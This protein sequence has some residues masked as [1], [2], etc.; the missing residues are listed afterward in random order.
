MLEK[1]RLRWN[2]SISQMV[3]L[4]D[5]LLNV[6][7]ISRNKLELR[8]ERAELAIVIQ[9][10]VETSR[11][12]IDRMGHRLSVTL[13]PEPLYLDADPT[14]L[15]QVFMNLLNNAAKYTDRGGHI[16]VSASGPHEVV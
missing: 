2:A 9:A 3:R 16:R 4:V 1:V 10:A 14:R 13:P 12:M 15:A 8:K 7:R 5:D 11:S 6:S